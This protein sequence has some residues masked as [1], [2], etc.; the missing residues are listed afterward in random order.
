MNKLILILISFALSYTSTSHAYNKTHT[1]YGGYIYGKIKGDTAKGPIISYRYETENTWGLLVSLLYLNSDHKE[2]FND[3]R[4]TLPSII[5]Y[6][7]KTTA[8]LVGPTYRL[9]SK[10]SIYAQMGPNK[11]KHQEDKY[12]PEIN[13]TDTHIV[14]T[15]SVIGHI[16]I[17]YNPLKDVSLNFGYLYSDTTANKRHIELNSLQLSLGYRF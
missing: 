11:L 3:P 1:L 9:S 13:T 14:N 7:N 10:I 6:R 12:H 2:P 4:F 8:L 16:G 15:T 17:D 5:K